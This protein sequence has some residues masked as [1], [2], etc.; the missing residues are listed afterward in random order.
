[1]VAP[2]ETTVLFHQGI[3]RDN[4]SEQAELSTDF[5]PRYLERM[6]NKVHA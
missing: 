6:A 1:M 2:I 5:I 4:Q 3:L